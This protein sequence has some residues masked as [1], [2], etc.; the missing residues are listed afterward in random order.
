MT[1]LLKAHDLI[2]SPAFIVIKAAKEF[3]D[4]TTALNEMR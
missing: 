4:K 2:I 3:T 1:G